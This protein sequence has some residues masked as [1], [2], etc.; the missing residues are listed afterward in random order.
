MG[1]PFCAGMGLLYGNKVTF[2]EVGLDP[3]RPPQDLEEVRQLA[4][5]VV[6]RHGR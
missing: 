6:A 5:P 3:E 4:L 1:E 2:R